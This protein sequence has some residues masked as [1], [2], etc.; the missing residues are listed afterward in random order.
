MGERLLQL[1]LGDEHLM[2]TLA[3]KTGISGRAALIVRDDRE[4]VSAQSAAANAGVLIETNVLIDVL[5]FDGNSFDVAIAHGTAWPLAECYRV[6]RAGGR[7]VVLEPGK[8]TG[9]SGW[10]RPAAAAPPSGD[11]AAALQGAGFGSVRLL[12]DREGYRFTE[13]F[14]R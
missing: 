12:A 14:K 8:R 13:A 2:T 1:G 5:P 6:L 4:F 7:L 11:A 10:F 3:S 9:M